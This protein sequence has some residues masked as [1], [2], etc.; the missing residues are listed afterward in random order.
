MSCSDSQSRHAALQSSRRSA[1]SPEA[2]GAGGGNDRGPQRRANPIE[3]P[4]RTVKRA[5]ASEPFM[6]MSTGQLM[7]R[8][9][10]PPRDR[11]RVVARK[12]KPVDRSVAR[13]ESGGVFRP[14]LVKK[15]VATERERPLLQAD[16]V[17]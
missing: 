7:T 5:V 4:S 12:A 9:L 16:P 15:I 17:G 14:G 6:S 3:S 11:K 13:Y 8:R 1:T 2:V 10:D